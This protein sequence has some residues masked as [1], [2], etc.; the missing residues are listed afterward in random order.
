MK[1]W[2]ALTAVF[3]RLNCGDEKW[4]GCQIVQ[5]KP[6]TAAWRQYS[7]IPAS[8]FS[9]RLS[10]LQFHT[11]MIIQM[12]RICNKDWRTMRCFL[13]GVLIVVEKGIPVASGPRDTD[14]TRNDIRSR[15]D[16]KSGT[17]RRKEQITCAWSSVSLCQIRP[18][19]LNLLW[20]ATLAGEG[21]GRHVNLW[22]SRRGSQIGQSYPSSVCCVTPA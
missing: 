16:G 22:I 13:D 9:S 6:L 21:C 19:I 7:S 12:Q 8:R 10:V 14:L 4:H 5:P 20:G 1:L 15:T 17:V 11:E 3:S 18:Q 2:S